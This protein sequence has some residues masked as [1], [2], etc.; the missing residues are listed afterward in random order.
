MPW[1]APRYDGCRL[2]GRPSPADRPVPPPGL[3]FAGFPS[4]LARFRTAPLPGSPYH[5]H[6]LDDLMPSVDPRRANQVG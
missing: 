6:W 5:S 2:A 3:A 4:A 1:H